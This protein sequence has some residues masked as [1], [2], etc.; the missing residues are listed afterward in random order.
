M[1]PAFR[2]LK[3]IC[4]PPQLSWPAG[5]RATQATSCVTRKR[6]HAETRRTRFW[7]ILREL[8]VRILQILQNP[9]GWPAVAGHDKGGAAGKLIVVVLVGA[10]VLVEVAVAAA[11]AIHAFLQRGLA[12]GRELVHVGDQALAPVAARLRRGAEPLHVPPAE[13]AQPPTPFALAAAP[14]HALFLAEAAVAAIVMIVRLAGHGSEAEEWD[15]RGG[16]FFH[17]PAQS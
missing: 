5:E 17:G 10:V 4:F 11:A 1:L 6:N 3:S 14:L 13:L 16:G 7:I 12:V 9:T 2:Y 8:R 15:G